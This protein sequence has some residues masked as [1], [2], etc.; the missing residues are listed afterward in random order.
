MDTIK[1]LK[2]LGFEDHELK[3]FSQSLSGGWKMRI[4]LAKL[5][6]RQPDI[7]Y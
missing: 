5:L 1:V 6:F 2:G 3:E 4:E 7:Y